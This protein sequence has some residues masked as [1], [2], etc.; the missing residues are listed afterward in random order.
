MNLNNNGKLTL[1]NEIELVDFGWEDDCIDYLLAV[2]NSETMGILYKLGMTNEMI[3]EKCFYD[4]G[5]IDI[6]PIAFIY[7]NYWSKEKGFYN[8]AIDKELEK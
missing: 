2:K 7:S 5:L 3:K 4:H 8:K 1:I 6:A